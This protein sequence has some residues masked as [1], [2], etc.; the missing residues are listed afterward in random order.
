MEWRAQYRLLRARQLGLT[1]AG[2]AV[3]YFVR[4]NIPIALPLLEEDLKLSKASLGAF[5]SGSDV[6]YGISKF[7]NGFLGDRASARW[8]MPVGLVLSA[9]FNGLFGLASSALALGIIWVL[10]GWFQGMGFPPCAKVM[11]HWFAVK[12]RGRMWGL[13]NVSHMV[14]AAGILVLAG[15]L[16]THYGWRA[17]FLVPAAIA[18]V[19]S[20]ILGIWLRDTPA[21]LGLPSAETYMGGGESDAKPEPPLS[22]EAYRAI[23]GKRVF[24][25]PVVWL[26]AVA[27]FFVYVV[28]LGFLNWAPTFLHEEKH[29]PLEWAGAMTAG[30]ELAGLVGS[31]VAGWLSDKVF[32]ARRAPVCVI[33]MLATTASIVGFWRIPEG[34]PAFDFALLLSIGFFIYG[35]QFLVGVMVTDQASKHA[36]AA[37]IGLT[38][39]FGYSSSLVS[40]VGLGAALDAWGWNG[41]FALLSAA[42]LVA[43]VPFALCWRAGPRED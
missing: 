35:P 43:S 27:N 15:W 9:L 10:N 1:F 19:M 13:W 37:A 34:H 28:R 7:L 33:F 11:A 20:I 4:K 2:Y 30:F 21:S 36:A 29:V 32:A 17:V 41:G 23:V 31:L 24:G 26:V 40:G 38:G 16:G 18:V 6:V 42:A 3:F 14:G 39:I 25:N 8:F 22:P 5:L 12:E